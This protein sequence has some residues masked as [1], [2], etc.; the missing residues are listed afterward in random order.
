MC[1]R[2]IDTLYLHIPAFIYQEGAKRYSEMAEVPGEKMNDSSK[3]LMADLEES[4]TSLDDERN[5][6]IKMVRFRKHKD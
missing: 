2:E 1:L 3:R 5:K 6:L 4:L